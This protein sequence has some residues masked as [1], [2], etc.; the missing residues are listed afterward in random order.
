MPYLV[1]YNNAAYARN[2]I[3]SIQTAIVQGDGGR[4][5]INT[6]HPVPNLHPDQILV[7]VAAV[8]LN[9]CDFKMA[10][11]FPS[12]GATDGCDFSGTVVAIG[13]TASQT[14]NFKLGDRVFGAVHGSN[15]IDHSSGSFAEYVAIDAGF[16]FKSPDNISDTTAAGIGGTGLGTLGL[17]LYKSLG[18]VGTPE[19]PVEN[20]PFVLVYGGSTSVG[21]LAL[22][23]LR[24]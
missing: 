14:T 20:G 4:L 2:D 17:V 9:P 18:L 1:R 8:A 15:P 21:T 12:S 6:S 3:P 11:R 16:L 10:S 22:Q 23:L 19:K 13:T 7:K 5:Y 24:L